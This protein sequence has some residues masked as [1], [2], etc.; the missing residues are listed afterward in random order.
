MYIDYSA[1]ETYDYTLSSLHLDLDNPRINYQ[2]K[3]LNQTQIIAYLIE[4][5]NVYKLAK[6]ISEEGYFIGE[7]PIIYIDKNNKKIVLEGN[8]RTAALKILQDPKKYLPTSRAN[9]LIKN[10]IAN[11][12]PVN[13]K[14]K[15]HI[16]PNRLLANP[17]IY[18]RHR[19]DALKRWQTGNQYAFVANMYYKDG[20]SIEDICELLYENSGKIKDYLKAYNLFY[21]AQ[22]LHLK[23]TGEFVD[24]SDFDITNL[25]RFYKYE[26]AKEFLG[27]EFDEE[28]ASLTLTILRSEFEKR[29]LYI[30]NEMLESSGFSRVFNNDN[31]K[32][33][34]VNDLKNKPIFN[35]NVSKNKEK[36]KGKSQG[37]RID[38]DNEKSKVNPR[39]KSRR[40]STLSN[41]IIPRDYYLSFENEKLDLLFE[42]LKF[43]PIERYYSFAILIRTYL[44]QVLFHYIQKQ[45][46]TQKINEKTNE[47]RKKDGLA[48]VNTL[49]KMIKGKY[50]INEDINTDEFMKILK[51]DGEK[52]YVSSLKVMLDYIKNHELKQ[53][54]SEPTKLKS[55][56]DYI[57]GVKNGLDLAVHNI[58]YTI[59]LNVNRRAW[60]T[61]EPLFKA[62]S[63][64]LNKI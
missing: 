4:N 9:I 34:Y 44:E 26:P 31:D 47:Q 23:D 40:K 14:L 53:I 30:F 41:F 64:N 2:G 61:L 8:R 45:E 10:I 35:Q 24:I 33:K 1:W 46:L 55:I 43:L 49:I 59:D 29:L 52:E 57:D 12:F 22:Q 38:L 63:D 28:D 13:K 25:E 48:K 7:E 51:F 32:E 50:D 15:C 20:L 58:D 18:S 21:E 17:I 36:S 54:I 6:K 42:E 37:I 5:E 39:R 56:T 16:A 60:T 62:L 19:G 3:P 11:D 27:I